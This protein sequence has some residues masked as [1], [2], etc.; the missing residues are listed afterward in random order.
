MKNIC[1]LFAVVTVFLFSC[2]NGNDSGSDPVPFEL[3]GSWSA[4]NVAVG[5]GVLAD[6][7]TTFTQSTFSG[8]TTIVSPAEEVAEYL[9]SGVIVSVSNDEDWYVAKITS[10]TDSNMIDKYGR[11]NYTLADDGLSFTGT[12]YSYEDSE[13]AAKASETVILTNVVCIKE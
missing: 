13:E 9:S 1:F 4:S 8:T 10:A 3:I 6:I 5:P 11:T 2:D 7:S 12:S